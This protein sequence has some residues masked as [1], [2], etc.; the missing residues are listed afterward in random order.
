MSVKNNRTCLKC[1]AELDYDL[2]QSKNEKISKEFLLKIWL[3]DKLQFF[4]CRCIKDRQ[5]I[6]FFISKI[7][8]ILPFIQ[9]YRIQC[10][11]IGQGVIFGDDF[12]WKYFLKFNGI[13]SEKFKEM[14]HSEITHLVN[15]SNDEIYQGVISSCI[16][17]MNR[18]FE[19]KEL[20]LSIY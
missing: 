5:E 2:Y 4:C 10:L 20:Y 6:E 19:I 15:L 3:S 13:F 1:A 7:R 9:K 17:A 14:T 12:F 8:D 16:K 18:L 11:E